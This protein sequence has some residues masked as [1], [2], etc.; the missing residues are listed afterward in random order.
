M[1]RACRLAGN[2]GGLAVFLLAGRGSHVMLQQ[3]YVVELCKTKAGTRYMYNWRFGASLHQV[4]FKP[5]L[6]SCTLD[7]CS[8]RC[9]FV[10]IRLALEKRL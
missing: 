8:I 5:W 4:V 3:G 6:L 9:C 2:A 7:L 10:E 1:R